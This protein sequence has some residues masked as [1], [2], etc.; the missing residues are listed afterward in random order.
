MNS[1]Q[2][3]T[4]IYIKIKYGKCEKFKHSSKFSRNSEFVVKIKIRVQNIVWNMV[5][6]ILKRIMKILIYKN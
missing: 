5:C 6:G 3:P 1:Y 4:F 2:N